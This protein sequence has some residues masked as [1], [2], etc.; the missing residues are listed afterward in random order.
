MGDN[1]PSFIS[2]A[3][4]K[5]FGVLPAADARIERISDLLHLNLAQI[6]GA[7]IK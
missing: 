5:R 3:T 1:L 4:E 7:K 2:R 6:I